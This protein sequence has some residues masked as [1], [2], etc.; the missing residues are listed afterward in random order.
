MR[1][2]YEFRVREKEFRPADIWPRREGVRVVP[3][4]V[5]ERSRLR[6]VDCLRAWLKREFWEVNLAE[7]YVH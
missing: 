7:G 2:E 1:S 3:E 5:E 4:G 6:E